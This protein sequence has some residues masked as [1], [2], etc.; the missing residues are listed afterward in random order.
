MRNNQFVNICLALIVGLLAL[1]IV[2]LDTSVYAAKKF[3]YE[4]VRANEGMSDQNI[5]TLVE[6]ETQAGWELVAA[7]MW[8]VD[9]SNPAEGVLIFRK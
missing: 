5:A 2:R 9:V 1:L 3:K 6:K 7:P 4:V 8:R